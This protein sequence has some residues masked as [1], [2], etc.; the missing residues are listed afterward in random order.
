MVLGVLEACEVVHK[1]YITNLKGGGDVI[2][3]V[4]NSICAH[5]RMAKAEAGCA[6]LR[7]R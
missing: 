2:N 7:I 4:A 1:G 6:A 5:R 3:T